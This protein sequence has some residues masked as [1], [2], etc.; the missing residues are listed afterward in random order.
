MLTEES[1]QQVFKLA[2]SLHPHR[3]VAW[4]VA[5]EAFRQSRRM[6]ADQ[7]SRPPAHRPYKHKLAESNLLKASVFAASEKWEKDQESRA[8]KEHP[9]YKP[10][11]EDLLYRYIKTLVWHSMER[12]SIYAAISIGGLLFR[13]S[14]SEIATISPDF[15]DKENKRRIKGWLLKKV[16]S[17]F[18]DVMAIP[19]ASGKQ[20]IQRP[21]EYQLAFVNK[22]LSTLA[23]LAEEHPSACVGTGTLFDK[24][25]CFDTERTEQD[26][27]HIIM[28]MECGGWPRLVDEYNEFY[29]GPSEQRLDDPAEKLRL[30]LFGGGFSNPPNGSEGDGGPLLFSHR[31]DPEPL[32]PVEVRS[33][34]Q[35]LDHPSPSCEALPWEIAA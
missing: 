25:F 20:D 3:V 28:N 16:E 9:I 23:P 11:T 10:T 15:F 32:N 4:A 19:D 1:V 13:Y 6:S 2:H 35:R 31:F 17:R 27:A 8:P 26:R 12:D 22:S 33:L 30:P 14:T 29:R 7:A 34:I 18:R 21:T 24:Y 5:R